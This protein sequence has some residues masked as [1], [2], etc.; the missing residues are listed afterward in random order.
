MNTC[1]EPTCA[2]APCQRKG[3]AEGF[4]CSAHKLG[5]SKCA[6]TKAAAEPK[7]AAKKTSKPVS[8][9]AAEATPEPVAKP[10]HRKPITKAAPKPKS[11]STKVTKK[12]KSAGSKATKPPKAPRSL[13]PEANEFDDM[14]AYLR[15]AKPRRTVVEHTVGDAISKQPIE[16]QQALHEEAKEYMVENLTDLGAQV[17][18]VNPPPFAYAAL[19]DAKIGKLDDQIFY[20]QITNNVTDDIIKD[21]NQSEYTAVY[22]AASQFN[23][24]EAMG[25]HTIKPGSAV[26]EYK[27]DP[28]QGPQAQLAFQPKQVNLI[29]NGANIGF[30]V[31][32]W[33]LTELTKTAVRHGYLIPSV[34]QRADISRA[35]EQDAERIEF[36]CIANKPARYTP[37]PELKDIH[38]ITF[39]KHP[40]HMILV[41]AAA[42]AN[43]WKDPHDPIL[44][45]IDYKCAL[46]AFGA[47][48]KHTQELVKKGHTVWL[49]VAAI[50]MGAFR[51]KPEVVAKAFYQVASKYKFNKKKVKVLFQVYEPDPKKEPRGAA[52]EVARLLGLPLFK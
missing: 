50:G 25:P 6:S 12:E 42:H 30:N 34:E 1:G 20:Y 46:N 35:L 3:K 52:V 39:S 15:A 45:E 23:G 21:G 14:T 19:K 8:K 27:R 49:K 4:K 47:Q 16:D 41:S 24:A 43:N 38:P 29:N 7:P 18:F 2:G 13:I 44:D 33:I 17:D 31:L 10:S 51:N 9:P 37:K 22:S 40:V 36:M 32:I 48:F 11:A 26:Y 28:T 5:K